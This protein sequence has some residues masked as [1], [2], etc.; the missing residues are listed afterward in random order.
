MF[1]PLSLSISPA[2]HALPVCS[3]STPPSPVWCPSLRSAARRLQSTDCH[4]SH[5]A[6]ATR[7]S[8]CL[9][10]S[11]SASRAP[12]AVVDASRSNKSTNRSERLRW[13]VLRTAGSTWRTDRQRSVPITAA[14]ALLARVEEWKVEEWSLNQPRLFGTRYW[15]ALIDRAVSKEKRINSIFPELL[16]FNYRSSLISF[17][18]Y[19]IWRVLTSSVR[20][21]H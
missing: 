4:R 21:D 17:Y 9:R 15:R 10:R 12:A 14:A 3:T 16:K 1:A 7:N 19:L 8:C 5:P 6:D 18:K 2:F 11:R 20:D 13:A